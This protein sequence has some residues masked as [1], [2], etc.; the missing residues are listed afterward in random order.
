MFPAQPLMIEKVDPNR[1]LSGLAPDASLA[2]ML[3]RGQI[4]RRTALRES[5][6]ETT[7]REAREHLR[8]AR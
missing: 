6:G 4:F 2:I 8:A 7:I 1:R 5:P 3:V